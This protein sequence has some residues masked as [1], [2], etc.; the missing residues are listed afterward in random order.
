M[1]FQRHLGAS[2]WGTLSTY[3]LVIRSMWLNM[4]L[5]CMLILCHPRMRT[6]DMF[7]RILSQEGTKFCR[8]SPRYT[9]F[10][11]H[12]HV[13]SHHISCI[14][15]QNQGIVVHHRCQLCILTNF[16]SDR[17][18]TRRSSIS[19]QYPELGYQDMSLLHTLYLRYQHK[20]KTHMEYKNRLL[21]HKSLEVHQHTLLQLFFQ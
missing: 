14:C 9:P 7:S 10:R 3:H 4:S 19:P 13:S 1:L 11:S 15:H 12:Q 5:E 18:T 20:S 17:N 16:P 21:H 6:R 2:S 8:I